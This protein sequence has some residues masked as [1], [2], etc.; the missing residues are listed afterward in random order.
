MIQVPE[1][2]EQVQVIHVAGWAYSGSTLLANVIGQADGVFAAGEMRLVWQRG[3]VENRQCGCG[4][5]FLDCPIWSAVV[6]EAF[7]GP[8]GIDA[9]RM[10]ALD[11]RLLL[12]R[13]APWYLA[14]RPAGLGLHAQLQEY[15]D[16]LSALFRALRVVTGAAAIVDTSKPPLYGL[17]LAMLP[18][19]DLR[20]VQLFRDPR[21]YLLSQRRRGYGP[22]PSF[23]LVLWD[24]NHVVAELS[25]VMRGR[26]RHT[27][28]RYEDFA[29]A[30]AKTSH[31]LAAAL[32]GPDRV[33]DAI[34]G[35][36]VTLGVNHMVAGNPS[37]LATGT[38]EVQA[39][40]G[41][42][43]ALP[44]SQRA[45][46]IAITWPLL[47]RHGYLRRRSRDELSGSAQSALGLVDQPGQPEL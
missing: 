33:T 32:G 20:T 30:P 7:G 2:L 35:N 24:V 8:A 23:A 36:R 10:V 41:W 5:P 39:D 18:A 12:N 40:E 1:S 17:L 43:V 22:R 29:R 3:L 42:R 27:V 25:G 38:I 47:L 31:D 16:A 21:G 15:A 4:V 45:L 34:A 11:A 6:R 9:A 46:A 28:V 26:G 37:R 19:V 44:R 14:G 13:R